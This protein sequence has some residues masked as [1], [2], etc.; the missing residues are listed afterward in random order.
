MTCMTFMRPHRYFDGLKVTLTLTLL[1]LGGE[2]RS[3]DSRSLHCSHIELFSLNSLSCFLAIHH[4]P[5][6]VRPSHHLTQ[7]AARPTLYR[8]KRGQR[9]VLMHPTPPPLDPNLPTSHPLQ[10]SRGSA[11]YHARILQDH[12]SAKAFKAKTSTYHVT[13]KDIH[14]VLKERKQEDEIIRSR[15]GMPTGQARR[16]GYVRVLNSRRDSTTVQVSRPDAPDPPRPIEGVPLHA[17]HNATTLGELLLSRVKSN[18][19]V[20][21]ITAVPLVQSPLSWASHTS[22]ATDQAPVAS[23]S[24]NDDSAHLSS[25]TVNGSFTPIPY[26]WSNLRGVDLSG[27]KGVYASDRQFLKPDRTTLP[28]IVDSPIAHTPRII[29]PD[30]PVARRDRKTDKRVISN[31]LNSPKEVEAMLE[32]NGTSVS[33]HRLSPLLGDMVKSAESVLRR[34]AQL[35]SVERHRLRGVPVPRPKRLHPYRYEKAKLKRES[36]VLGIKKKVLK[37]EIDHG[38]M[39][40][41]EGKK[42]IKKRWQYRVPSLTPFRK[43]LPLFYYRLGQTVRC[44]VLRVVGYGAWVDIG[45]EENAFLHVSHMSKDGSWSTPAATSA[46]RSV[47]TLPVET[48]KVTPGEFIDVTIMLI[49]LKNRHCLVTTRPGC[50][51]PNVR[52]WRYRSLGL[53]SDVRPMREEQC[54][55]HSP[56][57]HTEDD[58]VLEKGT[59]WQPE[60]DERAVDNGDNNADDDE[61]DWHPL[62]VGTKGDKPSKQ[63]FK[64]AKEDSGNVATKSENSSLNSNVSTLPAAWTGPIHLTEYQPP[65]AVRRIPLTSLSVDS[66]VSGKVRRLNNLGVML[67]VGCVVDAFL[68]VIDLRN[69]PLTNKPSEGPLGNEM[70]MIEYDDEG[71]AVGRFAKKER[72]RSIGKET[73]KETQ[74]TG[75]L[76]TGEWKGVDQEGREVSGEVELFV[77]QVF[78]GLYVKSIDLIRN[79]L[80]VTPWPFMSE[81]ERRIEFGFESFLEQRKF[82]P[83]LHSSF[84]ELN[85]V[86]VAEM[87]ETEFNRLKNKFEKSNLPVP[88]GL[89][90]HVV[91]KVNETY[92]VYVEKERESQQI[93]GLNPRSSVQPDLPSELR[94]LVVAPLDKIGESFIHRFIPQQYRDH[95]EAI[96]VGDSTH[97]HHLSDIQLQHPF[98]LL[99]ILEDGPISDGNNSLT[100][101]G[102]E[103]ASGNLQ[104]VLPLIEDPEFK[105]FG[106]IKES[107]PAS[108][109]SSHCPHPEDVNSIKV[110][111]VD[112]LINLPTAHSLGGPLP[113]KTAMGDKSVFTQ[114]QRQRTIE[115]MGRREDNTLLLCGRDPLDS[116]WGKTKVKEASLYEASLRLGGLPAE[117]EGNVGDGMMES[118]AD[119]GGDIAVRRRMSARNESVAGIEE[120][121]AATRGGRGMSILKASDADSALE[122]GMDSVRLSETIPGT[123]TSLLPG[124][125]LDMRKRI[126]AEQLAG[127]DEAEQNQTEGQT[128]EWEGD[129]KR[130]TKVTA[131]SRLSDAEAVIASELSEDDFVE[132]GK[133]QLREEFEV[134]SKSSLMSRYGGGEGKGDTKF[135]W[136]S[137]ALGVAKE[138]FGFDPRTADVIEEQ[139]FGPPLYKRLQHIYDDYKPY[140]RMGAHFSAEGGGVSQLGQIG[141]WGES[142]NEESERGENQMGMAL[143]DDPFKE[144]LA[145][146]GHMNDV[147]RQ[148]RRTHKKEAMG[149]ESDPFKIYDSDPYQTDEGFVSIRQHDSNDTSHHSPDSPDTST[150]SSSPSPTPPSPESLLAELA[151]ISQSLG[152]DGRPKWASLLGDGLGGLA[153]RG[154]S[155]D[156]ALRRMMER[157]QGSA[158]RRLST[159]MAESEIKQMNE[160]LMHQVNLPN[161][162]IEEPTTL[163]SITEGKDARHCNKYMDPTSREDDEGDGACGEVEAKVRGGVNDEVNNGESVLDDPAELFSRL[164]SDRRRRRELAQSSDM[165]KGRSMSETSDDVEGSDIDKLIA[166][167]WGHQRQGKEKTSKASK[168]HCRDEVGELDVER[169]EVDEDDENRR[170]LLRAIKD[171]GDDLDIGAALEKARASVTLKELRDRA[172]EDARRTGSPESIRLLRH[173]LDEASGNEALTPTD[174]LGKVYGVKGEEDTDET[175]EEVM[176]Q[177]EKER[178]QHWL[179]AME[180]ATRPSRR[181]KRGT[182][183]KMKE[184]GYQ[185]EGSGEDE[186]NAN[187]MKEV[188]GAS[189]ATRGL[190]R[191]NIVAELIKE[192]G[193]RQGIASNNIKG[194]L[195]AQKDG[196]D[197]V[198]D[199][200]RHSTGPRQQPP[201]PTIVEEGASPFS[202]PSPTSINQ[203]LGLDKD[204]Y[205]EDDENAMDSISSASW[206]LA[207]NQPSQLQGAHSVARQS[208][209]TPTH[210]TRIPPTNGPLRIDVS[211]RAQPKPQTGS[212]PNHSSHETGSHSSKNPDS[213][214]HSYQPPFSS[215]GSTRRQQWHVNSEAKMVR[216]G[217]IETLFRD[218][219][220]A[221]CMRRVGLTKQHLF[222][223]VLTPKVIV[224][225]VRSKTAERVS[226]WY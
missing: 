87:I 141:Q 91:D 50:V 137:E 123:G 207:V 163:A 113:S 41:A 32:A 213:F 33:D 105:T 193:Q 58:M 205:E 169:H 177:I 59:H 34:T 202:S 99:D 83:A 222:D 146:Q 95:V 102:L 179:E 79:R 154:L 189:G 25:L 72:R 174:G 89:H 159:S 106:H 57:P 126:I 116:L 172:V 138:I 78:H 197:P 171:I 136:S 51:D 204:P 47:G 151:P 209:S 75:G 82:I 219:V 121:M 157:M 147:R 21:D 22:S 56:L 226:R 112:D 148:T 61:D 132:S 16:L 103:R 70:G 187:E 166:G 5:E 194:R 24:E 152:P 119:D 114:E 186:A 65:P 120:V 225:C 107:S 176:R 180:R 153:M 93:L 52:Q 208:L 28:F 223:S 203:A 18:L 178:R 104:A 220:F 118:R 97:L 124:E 15:L 43:R 160:E 183:G 80:Q 2:A 13:T 42:M 9:V 101:R 108:P 165:G 6:G 31:Q 140:E 69:S 45:A 128:D 36:A 73:W 135:Q 181:M 210:V 131:A 64:Y 143:L 86:K 224:K 200:S 62:S 199:P 68:H 88:R 145:I 139:I 84:A 55:H 23:L 133:S 214:Q 40:F 173:V 111:G 198:G 14:Q 29:N 66:R 158:K 155:E 30:M 12:L 90:A 76:R 185:H 212:E 188:A 96:N 182:R 67:D 129:Q 130:H 54:P 122:M 115:A 167:V 19:T 100:Q 92:K 175:A 27:R 150:T 81:M 109:L 221:S 211:E 10:P 94:P 8:K 134:E 17:L 63:F 184:H 71:H 49:D 7:V 3:V 127:E 215:P 20:D 218:K 164:Q 53:G 60:E 190:I 142:P 4:P 11:V 38:Y 110:R 162:L 77:G 217:E 195:K 26:T 168:V 170:E 48:R 35:P 161:E 144:N 156:Y 201:L 1:I 46:T 74:L 39:R 44:R 125:R 37:K 85:Q 216:A 98:Q 149:L 192:V 206:L 191:D 196:S 117:K